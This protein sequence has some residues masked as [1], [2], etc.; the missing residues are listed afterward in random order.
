LDGPGGTDVE[1]VDGQVLPDPCP[2]PL[3][4][5]ADLP[6]LELTTEHIESIKRPWPSGV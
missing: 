6:L 3:A 2:L 5:L 4:P 1:V